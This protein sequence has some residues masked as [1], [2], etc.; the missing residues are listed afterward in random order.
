MSVSQ[1]PVRFNSST[2]MGEKWT[3]KK[4]LAE[5]KLLMV[6]G[7]LV[8]MRT[9]HVSPQGVHWDAIGLR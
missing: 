1:D 2:H 4:N 3:E 9:E 8:M 7:A 6:T 5:A